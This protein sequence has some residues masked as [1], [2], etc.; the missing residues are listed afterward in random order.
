MSIAIARNN[1][2]EFTRF[3]VE[4]THI[5][6]LFGYFYYLLALFNVLFDKIDLNDCLFTTESPSLK[7]KTSAH[8]QPCAAMPNLSS[9]TIQQQSLSRQ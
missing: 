5:Y 3:H 1:Y 4:R 6:T 9:R 7:K 2:S 8:Q